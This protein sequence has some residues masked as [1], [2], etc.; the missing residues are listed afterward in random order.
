[1]GVR[2]L[3]DKALGTVVETWA[4]A[5]RHSLFSFPWSFFYLT[6]TE[7]FKLGQCTGREC[8]KRSYL[9]EVENAK[10]KDCRRRRIQIWVLN[11]LV[12]TFTYVKPIPKHRYY[13]YY[14]QMFKNKRKAQWALPGH[15]KRNQTIKE[16]HFDTSLCS[17]CFHGVIQ[18]R[19]G[20]NTTSFL[21]HS[22]HRYRNIS[23]YMWLSI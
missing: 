18:K 1:M 12:Y 5:M 21:H 19:F 9:W 10:L 16:S 17:L 20:S 11:L 8:K 14:F 13:H 3:R 23:V 22:P 7:G 4:F 15:T 6:P 2:F